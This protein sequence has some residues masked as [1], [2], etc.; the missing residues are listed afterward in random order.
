MC[1]CTSI[2]LCVY[3]ASLFCIIA[4]MLLLCAQVVFHLQLTLSMKG[5]RA[6]T[7]SPPSLPQCCP[8]VATRTGGPYLLCANFCLLLPS[9]SSK[10][11]CQVT[12][13]WVKKKGT[14]GCIPVLM[15]TLNFVLKGVCSVFH[16][17]KQAGYYKLYVYSF[18]FECF[19]D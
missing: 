19:L 11:R 9:A 6:P 5:I 10:D 14:A 15:H 13:E 3:V 8:L 18:R 4:V 17:L 7:A 16:L 2:S 1:V 12:V